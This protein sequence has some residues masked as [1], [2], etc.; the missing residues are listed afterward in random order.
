MP[1]VSKAQKRFM[2]AAA[3]NPEFAKKAGIEQSVAKDFNKADKSRPEPKV[4]RVSKAEK[5]YGKA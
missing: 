5:R 2:A 1:S 4:E 3:H